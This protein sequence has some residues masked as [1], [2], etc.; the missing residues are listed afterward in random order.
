MAEREGF[1]PSVGLWPTHDFQSCALDQLS[2]LSIYKT[3]ETLFL[4]LEVLTRLELVNEG[5]ADLC[6]TNLATAPNNGAAYEDRTRYLHLGKVALY[7][8]S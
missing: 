1:E 6:L 4:L 7:Q 2:H 8:M 5:F 3:E